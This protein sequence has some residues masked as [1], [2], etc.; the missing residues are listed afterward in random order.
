MLEEKNYI[1]VMSS[2]EKY[3]FHCGKMF[4]LESPYFSS[5][6]ILLRVIGLWPFQQTKL[7]RIQ[8]SLFFS[9]MTTAVIFQ[10]RQ[11]FRAVFIY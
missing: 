3:V 1:T 2:T 4:H 10:V 5:N 8:F 11:Y 9:I 7:A 6:E